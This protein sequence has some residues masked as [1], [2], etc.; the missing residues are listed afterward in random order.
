MP[1]IRL[2]ILEDRPADATLM[3][4]ELQQAG[5]TLEWQRVDNEEAYLRHLD[6]PPDLIL[7]DFNMPQFTAPAALRLLKER[8]LDVPFIIV[9]GSI[10]EETA[11]AVLRDG[12]AD[13]LLKDRMTRL[14]A[15][16]T[17]ALDEKQLRDKQRLAEEDLARER[18]LLRTL[19]DTLPDF[20]NIKDAGGRYRLVN[21]AYAEFLGAG[22]PD[23]IIGK[24]VFDVFPREL[25]TGY[26]DDDRH[27][28][29]TGQSLINKETIAIT[30]AQDQRW[31]LVSKIPLRDDH[32]NITGLV[33]IARDITDRKA[34]EEQIEQQLQQ[35]QAL[36][37]ID[38]AITASLDLR[39]TLNVILDQVTT[40]LRAD[41]ANVLL[42]DPHTQTLRH[43]TNRGFRTPALR[44]ASLRLGEGHAGKAALEQHTLSVPDLA[45][46]P[47][48]FARSVRLPEEGFV[49]Y[50]A[51]P[52]IAKGQVKGVLEIFH[53]SPLHP[54]PE[55]MAF[56]EAL[57]GQAAIAVDNSS[58]FDN[59]QRANMDLV[60]A[61][62]TTLEGWSKALDLRD[63]ETEGHTLRVTQL[64]VKL[65]RRLGV[66]DADLVHVRRG[67][68]L[69][70]I[71]KMGIPDGILLKPGPLTEDEWVVMRKHPIYAYELLAPIPYLRLALDVP[72]C[73]HEKWDGTGYPRGL[74]G[75]AIPLAARIFAVVDVYDALTSDRPY[76][77]AWPRE[78]TLAHIREHT[79]THFDPRIVDA[80]LALISETPT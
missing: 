67:A 45:V 68:L 26:A 10:G 54:T 62:D 80:F 19:I 24:T 70:D 27:V 30:R 56:L 55:W 31:H 75:D 51:V 2:L 77:A 39:V 36:R 43:V 38:I 50:H 76:R 16:A 57:A 18:N 63:K 40:H 7:A 41:A 52:L 44:R 11:V 21:H 12:A 73:H 4:A 69:H 28:L 9:S 22:A 49:A 25:A 72:Y 35:L 61:Y 8:K 60:M 14:A 64:T 79:G 48:E 6:P 13:Y 53:R 34:A 78:K 66:G 65:A 15:A 37:H 33:G 71:G 1:H 3:V 47:G 46:E 74:N 5:F 42:F 29:A 59:L 58:L 20:I 23:D 32:G 17:R